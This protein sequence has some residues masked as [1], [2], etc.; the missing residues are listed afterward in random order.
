[1]TAPDSELIFSSSTNNAIGSRGEAH[2]LSSSGGSEKFE[3]RWPSEIIPVHFFVLVCF[4]M[5]EVASECQ[6]RA[7]DQ[8]IL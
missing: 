1:M 3:L 7:I 6:R 5:R 2:C 8:N 4:H